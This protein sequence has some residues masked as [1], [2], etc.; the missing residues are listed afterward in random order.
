MRYRLSR[1]FTLIELL[2][3]IAIIAVL[4]ALLLPAV[5]QAREAARRANCIANLK[6]IG[7]AMHNYHDVFDRLPP[8]AVFLGN[9]GVG[10]T[11]IVPPAPWT[12]SDSGSDADG[13]ANGWGAT[14]ATLILPYIDQS[15]VFELYNVSVVARAPDNTTATERK[16]NL[17]ACPSSPAPTTPFTCTL[18]DGTTHGGSFA[19]GNYAAFFSSNRGLQRGD[20]DNGKARV[21]SDPGGLEIKEGRF[22]YRTAMSA[23]AQWGVNFSE[24]H[25][26]L[27]T[28]IGWS[29]LL[30]LDNNMDSR[31]AWGYVAGPHLAAHAQQND[32]QPA[33]SFP[34]PRTMMTPN[35]DRKDEIPYCGDSTISAG[36]LQCAQ[37]SRA[38]YVAP[39]AFHNGG[40]NVGM[41]DGGVRFMANTVD[42]VIFYGYTTVQ[43]KEPAADF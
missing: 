8:G 28:T 21:L 7:I 27:A 43:G 42:H 24:V 5:Q 36:E 29:E 10:G 32:P 26:G 9:A 31:G 16:I 3:V 14:W 19:K 39:R 40:V 13:R 2:V 37:A 34:N 35:R 38:T 15:Q 4:I 23:A 17:Y 30:I 20:W 41:L 22:F 25:D 18:S 1:G 6:Q 33:I 11:P 12:I